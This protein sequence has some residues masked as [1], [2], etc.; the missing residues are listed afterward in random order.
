MRGDAPRD[1]VRESL[2]VG[3]H[4]EVAVLDE[5]ETCAGGRL[6]EHSGAQRSPNRGIR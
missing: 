6:V 3:L 1:L 2:V 5:Y 4:G